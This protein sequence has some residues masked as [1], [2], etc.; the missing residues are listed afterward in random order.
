MAAWV[1]V[2]MLLALGCGESA[3]EQPVLSQDGRLPRS[4]E[5]GE[6]DP[7]GCPYVDPVPWQSTSVHQQA[8][9]PGCEPGG[10]RECG[11]EI[12]FVGCVA[13]AVP[14]WPA[15]QAVSDVVIT[16][17]HPVNGEQY[18]FSNPGSALP[19]GYLCWSLGEF[20]GVLVYPSDAPDE[21]F[22]D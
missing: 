16:M 9:G 3:P 21:C 11:G 10:T 22:E 15:G 1:V 2:L 5:A 14:R 8:C 13:E 20:D 4:F 19:F 12:S 6:L 18:C 17:V 7:Y